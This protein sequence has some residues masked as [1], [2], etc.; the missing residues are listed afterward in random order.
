[1]SVGADAKPQYDQ[2]VFVSTKE[3]F[4]LVQGQSG[5]WKCT[6]LVEA[7]STYYDHYREPINDAKLL[8]RQLA[9]QLISPPIHLGQEP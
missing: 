5:T 8:N 4:F 9:P 3:Y 6:V 7:V 2:Y 1:M